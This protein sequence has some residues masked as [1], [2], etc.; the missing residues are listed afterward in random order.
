MED[1]IILERIKKGKL[2]FSILSLI[3]SITMFAIVFKN[4][5]L[6]HLTYTF[7]YFILAS[8]ILHS[9]GNILQSCE[10][11]D[12]IVVS[13]ISFSDVFT[14]LLFLFF[15]FCSVKI[16]KESNKLIINK[17][18]KYIITSFICA[19]IYFIVFLI[20]AIMNE[21]VD[22]RFNNYYH[23]DDKDTDN[24]N[25]A[26]YFSS[27]IHTITIIVISNFTIQYLYEVV[28]F[29]ND[30][31]KKDKINSLLILRLSNIF[32]RYGLICLLYWLFLI[33]RILLV[34]ICHKKD[35]T[36]RDIIYLFSEIFFSIRGF[37]IS[38]N[39]L[40]SSRI[41]KK[42]NEFI[43][44]NIKHFILVNLGFLSS[45]KIST[46]NINKNNKEPKVI[47]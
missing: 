36:F 29:L 43:E 46:V 24:F 35:N 47:D 22:L 1:N 18:K 17:L 4:R 33:P 26:F 9:I 13:F 41:Q 45:R 32:S 8:E 19:F 15:S 23:E 44:V 39:T 38:I 40:T 30:K 7:L 21:K 11:Y 14:N 42:I 5:Q 6:S 16:I 10:V 34:S 31:L 2:Y 28:V 20:I 12:K 25:E 37:L 27:L 3:T